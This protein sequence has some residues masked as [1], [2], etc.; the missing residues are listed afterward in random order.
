M[1][2]KIVSAL[3][4][5][6]PTFLF[7]FLFIKQAPTDSFLIVDVNTY[8][9]MLKFYLSS[10][11][12]GIYPLWDPFNVWGRPAGLNLRWLGEMNPFYHLISLL[13]FMGISFKNAFFIFWISYY[14]L[15]C[16]GLRML[17]LELTRKP[18]LAYC[19]YLFMLFSSLG[20]SLLIAFAPVLLYT[21]MVWF[22]YFLFAF[23]R[24]QNLKNA[25]GLTLSVMIINVTYLPFY[26]VIVFTFFLIGVLCLYPKI[27]MDSIKNDIRFVLKNKTLTFLLLI[28][29][30]ISVIPGALWYQQAKT[31]EIIMNWRQGGAGTDHMAYMALKHINNSGIIEGYDIAHLFGNF[32]DID[33]DDFFVSPFLFLILALG[34]AAP[35]NRRMAIL[36]GMI[37][38]LTCIGLT[39]ATPVHAFLYEH[40]FFFRIT[41]NLGYMLWFILPLSILLANE[42]LTFLLDQID[43]PKA[44]RLP[45]RIYVVTVHVACWLFLQNQSNPGLSGFI[46]IIISSTFFMGFPLWKSSRPALQRLI[47]GILIC[48]QPLLIFWP[49]MHQNHQAHLIDQGRLNTM[50]SFSRPDTYTKTRWG[51]HYYAFEDTSGFI[52]QEDS[53]S[54]FV[55]TK[56]V[57]MLQQTFEK[58]TLLP[59]VRHKFL[60]YD[61]YKTEGTPDEIVHAMSHLKNTAYI[62]EKNAIPLTLPESNRHKAVVLTEVDEDFKIIHFD[63]NSITFQTNWQENKLLVYNDSYHSQ[64]Q[65]KVDDKPIKI[66][67]TNF[68]FKGLFIPAG[69]HVV[70]MNFMPIW[71][72]H[73]MRLSVIIFLLMLILILILQTKETFYA[74]KTT[75]T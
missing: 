47:L 24:R 42:F 71:L 8:F 68:A 45:W 23:H 31:G 58:K 70:K 55:G 67:K 43:S 49:F 11:Q 15:G 40:I 17:A 73:F 69:H 51:Q 5:L 27:S 60:L 52:D 56:D 29:V 7:I 13:Q 75:T 1:R 22:F 64:W 34:I 14:L 53:G 10:I 9:H 36:A 32:Q 50:F 25:L 19:A 33:L 44:H 41:R 62:D 59:Y 2:T 21:C 18:I 57:S 30:G 37:F 63:L 4:Y 46:L 16:W 72:H 35:I 48:L 66:H 12:E 61:H 38:F 6:L 74:K 26:F 54:R 20:I 28:C 39:F 3:S 65:A